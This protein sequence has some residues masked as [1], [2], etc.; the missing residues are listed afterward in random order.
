MKNLY[1]A[2]LLI[3]F[4]SFTQNVYSQTQVVRGTVVEAESKYPVLGAIVE[5]LGDSATRKVQANDAGEF[6]FTGV[7]IGKKTLV[8]KATG[9]KDVVIDITVTSG[10]EVIINAQMEESVAELAELEILAVRR[11]EVNNEMATVSARSF[12]VE[13]TERYAGSRGDPAR[14]ASNFAGVQGADD[15]RNDIVVRGNSPLGVVYRLEGVD[16][17]NPNHFAIAGSMGGPIGVLNNKVLGNS[18]FFTGAFP[19]EFGNSTAAVFD[20]K[21]RNGNNEKHEFT[22]QLGFLGTELALEGPFSKN[23]KA[24]YL[25]A[26]RYSTFGLFDALGISIGTDAVPKYQDA[27]FKINL[28]GKKGGNFSIFGLGGSS[29]IAIMISDQEEPSTELYGQNDRDQYFKTRMGVFGVAYNKSLNENTFIKWTIMTSHD[30]QK[31]D[32]EF[33]IRHV[34]SVTNKYVVDSLYTIQGYEFN[35]NR[36]STAFS[37]NHKFSKKHILKAG[38]NFDLYTYNMIDSVLDYTHSF[39][40]NRWNYSGSGILAQPYIQWK[41]KASDDLTVTAGIHSQYFSV[42]NSISYAEP[43]VGLKYKLNEKHSVQVASGLHSQTQPHYVYFYH[44]QNPAGEYVLHN[45]NMDF[46]KSLHIVGGH[47]WRPKGAFRIM[48]EA[49]YQHVFNIPV[50]IK[51]NSYSLA[52]MGAGFARFFPDSLQNTGLGKNMG[53]EITIEKFFNKKYFVLVTASVFDARYQGSDKVWRNTDYNGKYAVNTL[54]GI[55]F[56]TGDKTTLSLGSKVTAA[57]GRWYGYVDRVASDT[58]LEVVYLDSAYNTRQFKPYFRADL[59]VNFRINGKKVSHELALDLVNI[60]GTKNILNLTY[61]P[62]LANP[63]AEPIREN[64][65]LGFLPLFYYKIDF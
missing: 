2:I 56:K 58:K 51:P 40:I 12:N 65:Q 1:Q 63:S 26:Y 19:A 17:P 24:S 28:P 44:L 21:F 29:S 50:G 59:K 38:V 45:K 22:G 49:Y 39:F 16:I 47:E 8:F 34:D 52:N 11:G 61:A 20:L 48:T 27:S 15:S 54:A 43:R 7:K 4:Y 32:H 25:G 33:I 10:K 30:R 14:M 60:L 23:S 18:D 37:I 55:E 13:E 35:T 57:G 53:V 36:Y 64:Y 46:T 42:S 31:S 5:L 3:A 41:W 9:F 6:R 62:D